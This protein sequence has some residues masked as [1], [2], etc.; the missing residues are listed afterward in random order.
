MLT[1][2]KPA[3]Y[4]KKV[5]DVFLDYVEP[6]LISL[7]AERPNATFEEYDFA[8][9]VPWMVWNAIVIQETKP[10]TT[11]YVKMMDQ[12]LVGKPPLMRDLVEF[13]VHRKR[14]EFSKYKYMI[15]EY[16]HY[17]REDGEI[18]FY[19]EARTNNSD[20]I[21]DIAMKIH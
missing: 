17:K 8:L 21:N 19:A 14:T 18:R 2:E 16:R 4:G 10:G 3:L 13:L 12:L 15:G 9:R 11:D 1:N 7:V 5:S 6:I 20:L